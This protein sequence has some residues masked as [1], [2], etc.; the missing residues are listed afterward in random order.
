MCCLEESALKRATLETANVI[1]GFDLVERYS[2]PTTAGPCSFLSTVSHSSVF[3]KSL[4]LAAAGAD[5]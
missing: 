1:S 3:C 5:F 2:K 4:T